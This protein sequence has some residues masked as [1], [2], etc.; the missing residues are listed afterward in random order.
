MHRRAARIMNARSGAAI[1]VSLMLLAAVAV[2]L[3]APNVVDAVSIL[4]NP[5]TTVTPTGA[6][7]TGAEYTFGRF[8]TANRENVTGC[9]ITFPAGTNVSGA[10]AVDPAG[11]VTVTGQTVRIT[12]TNPV[13]PDKTTFY[14]TIGGITNP[15]AGTYN[16]GNITMYW[17]NTQTGATGSTNLA[18]GNYTITN[19]FINMT[20]T[21]PAAGQS[22][23]FGNVDPEVTT[24]P[25]TVSITVNSSAPYTFTRTISDPTPLGLQVIG[26]PNGLKTVLNTTYTDSYTLTPPYTAPPSVP[27]TATVL[28][29]VVQ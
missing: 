14:V 13:V 23:N 12:F 2:M 11:T 20:I 21:T 6:G 1:A 22:V 4:G 25:Q 7:A 8:R 16:A 29:T 17:M 24:P 18:T 5:S 27:L 10:T 26:T 3:L 15:P 28:Y 9:Q 19:S